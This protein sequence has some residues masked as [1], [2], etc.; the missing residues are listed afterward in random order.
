MPVVGRF[1]SVTYEERI[2]VPWLWWLCALGLLTTLALAVFAYVDPWVGVLFTLFTGAA[3]VVLLLSYTQRI[4]V[5]DGVLLVGRNRLEAQYIGE[6][7]ALVGA[8]A[9]RALGPGADQRN[10]LI[11]RPFVRDLVRVGI[12]DPADPHPAWLV[13]T[14]RAE[15]LAENLRGLG[16][17]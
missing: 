4:R 2:P 17:D 10:F 3:L 8:E 9:Q 16:E 11:T 12:D 14:R 15:D 7:R 5:A 6:V 13:S 1:A